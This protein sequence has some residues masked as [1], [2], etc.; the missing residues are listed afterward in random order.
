MATLTVESTIIPSIVYYSIYEAADMQTLLVSKVTSSEAGTCPDIEL[1]V[2][3]AVDDSTIDANV[4]TVD[5]SS[6]PVSYS[7]TTESSDIAKISTYSYKVVAKYTGAAYTN[8]GEQAFQIVID[9]PCSTATLTVD[10]TIFSSLAIS[11]KIFYPTQIETLDVAKVTSTGSVNCPAY[12]FT[13]TDQSNAA[14]DGTVFTYDEPNLEFETASTN[15]TKAAVYPLRLSVRYDGDTAHYTVFGQKDFT[16]TLVD[17]CIAAT[18]T[19]NAANLTST[20]IT[21]SIYAP[22]DSQILSTRNVSSDETTATCP[23][24]EL[25]VLNSDGSALDSAVFTFTS[26]TSTFEIESSDISKLATY[27]LKVTAKYTGASYVNIGELYF[28]VT[29]MTTDLIFQEAFALL[30]GI[31]S[32]PIWPFD[33]P[34]GVNEDT[35]VNLSSVVFYID[36][37]IGNS[38]HLEFTVNIS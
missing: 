26:D 25:D 33:L 21:Y 22:A 8:T 38:P 20:S 18:L 6:A 3:V 14:I 24:V 12:L 10:D 28:T 15:M 31:D 32:S 17:P 37:V 4:F 29:L 2:V 9:D 19:V 23:A 7:L 27:N 36:S 16:I 5:G 35:T 11:Y 13:F 1:T 30:L 34:I